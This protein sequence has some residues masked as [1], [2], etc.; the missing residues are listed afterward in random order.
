V[1]TLSMPQSLYFF[2]PRSDGPQRRLYVH[3]T[4]LYLAAAGVVAGIALS[5][6]NPL[7]PE[8]VR[9]LTRFDPLVPAL[10]AA[11]AL[12]HLLDLLPTIDERVTWQARVVIGLSLIRVLGLALAAILT[13]E[14]RDLILVL[15]GVACLKL[16]L[17]GGYVGRFHGLGRPWLRWRAFAG[18]IRHAAPFGFSSALY[19]LR[20]QADQWVAASLF[21]LHSF[22]AFSIAAVLGPMINLFRVSV[23]H[24]FLPSMSRL[25][26]SGDLRAMLDL[27]SRANVMVAALA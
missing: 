20:V 1:T 19:S 14:V 16:V 9:S 15:L 13:G 2:L 5:E 12:A 6:W 24:A 21:P 27:N 25:E 22:A 23:N 11:W 8:S 10:V 4:M 18:Q 17:L 7:L 3:Q 26:A